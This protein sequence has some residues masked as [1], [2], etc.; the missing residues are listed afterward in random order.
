[1]F[2][3][4]LFR[5]ARTW[6]QPRCLINRWKDKEAVVHIYNGILHVCVLSHFSRVWLFGTLWN[7]ACQVPLSMGFSRQD[8]WSGLPCP[9]PRDLPA[10]RDQTRISCGSCI[11]C[12][13]GRFFI[14]EPPGKPTVE[15]SSAIKRDVFES[16]LMRWMNP[17]SII[18][19]E[20]G[21]KEKTKYH[22]LM[23]MEH[24]KMVLMKLF[25]GQQWSHEH[26]EQ[27]AGHFGGG[28]KRRAW[29]IWDIWRE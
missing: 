26:R 5:I 10:P 1:M 3:A 9:P 8:Y 13:A 25:E 11:S 18:Q 17:E 23:Y 21:Q 27:T 28:G 14:T 24:R 4:A 7:V 22:I 29:H 12:T 20:A 15:Y 16:V 2:T 6:K 19:S